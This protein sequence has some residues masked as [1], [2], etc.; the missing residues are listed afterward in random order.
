MI[1][2]LT[3]LTA[4]IEMT[5]L[6]IVVLSSLLSACFTH[7]GPDAIQPEQ[8][9]QRSS[10]S[11]WLQINPDPEVLA[12][13]K[14]AARDL[15]HDSVSRVTDAKRQNVL[16]TCYMLAFEMDSGNSWQAELYRDPHGQLTLLELL[17]Q[18]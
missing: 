8:P 4:S 18:Q 17:Q 6:A 13:A 3:A 11:Q 2:L 15:P 9:A 16:G 12:M 10:V 1:V 5:R 7:T 14:F